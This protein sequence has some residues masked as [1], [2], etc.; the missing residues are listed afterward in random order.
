[1]TSA[2]ELFDTH[3]HLD[4]VDFADCLSEVLDRAAQAGVTSILSLG[5]TLASSRANVLLAER[6]ASIYAAA[7]I[8]PNHCAESADSDWDEVVKLYDHPRVVAVGE[9]G[10][11]RYWDFV[12][13]DV[14]QD[15]FDRHL[16]A[17][18]ARDLPVVIHMRD[19]EADVLAMLREA[20]KRGP[21][22]GVM[23][24][25][26]A[27]ESGA[28]ECL[29]MG[30]YI[31]FAGMVTYKKSDEL[32]RIAA[33]IPE[34][35]ILVETDSPYLSPH[36]FRGQ[37]PNEPARVVHTAQCLA[38]ARATS[39]ATFAALAAANARRLFNKTQ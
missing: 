12:R 20:L 11:D 13:F 1:M 8:H 10:L 3:A 17:A 30:L 24:S 39:L 7:G 36:P 34:D 16:R 22:R 35:R 9:T 32:R 25:F 5:T 15:Y 26:A 27:S 2:V 33:L 31:S 4:H 14:Q 38:D 21:L 28:L 23:H 29:E 19:C 6:F 37:K 18:Q